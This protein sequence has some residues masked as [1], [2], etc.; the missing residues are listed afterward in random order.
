MSQ[1]HLRFRVPDV[2]FR[3]LIVGRAN[4]GKTSILQRVCETRESPKIYRVS[5]RTRE[6]VGP[7]YILPS[8]SDYHLIRFISILL[9]RSVNRLGA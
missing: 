2:K 8:V 9:L 6:E 3:V 5:G 4:A 7:S 1:Q